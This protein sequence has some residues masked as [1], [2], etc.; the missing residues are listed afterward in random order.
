MKPERYPGCLWS[1]TNHAMT[2]T[3]EIQGQRDL[4]RLRLHDAEQKK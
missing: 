2:E 3:P 4:E 1:A